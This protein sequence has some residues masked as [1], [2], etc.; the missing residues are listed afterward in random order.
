MRR[1]LRS[2]SRQRRSSD[3]GHTSA[4]ELLARRRGLLEGGSLRIEVP[5]MGK[6]MLAYG[7][8][9]GRKD[10]PAGVAAAGRAD[11]LHGGAGRGL[12]TSRLQPVAGADCGQR[13]GG[14]AWR[15]RWW[16]G[17]QEIFKAEV[18]SVVDLRQKVS[19]CAAGARIE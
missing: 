14:G 18:R 2:A 1:V 9:C 13:S 16:S 4:A 17:A 10:H 8:C 7:E 15:I 5:G 3:G 11:P 6:K 19:L 12:G